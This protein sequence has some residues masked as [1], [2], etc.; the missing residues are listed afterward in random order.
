MVR[1][2]GETA[3]EFEQRQHEH[4]LAAATAAGAAAGG[5]R[6]YDDN[7][8]GRADDAFASTETVTLEPPE[9]RRA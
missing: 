5:R 9:A 2:P 3:D 1:R 6:V 7:S 8:E 4:D